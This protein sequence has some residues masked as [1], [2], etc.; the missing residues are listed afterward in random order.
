M[1]IKLLANGKFL[2]RSTI[3][4]LGKRTERKR[5]CSSKQEALYW[6]KEF[7]AEL[8]KLQVKIEEQD[9]KLWSS[10]L[11]SYLA[12]AY[13]N[14]SRASA[15]N[16]EVC[17][18]SKTHDWM[19]KPIDTIK[20]EDISSAVNNPSYRY[21]YKKELL[22]F[23]RAVFEFSLSARI[24]D[25]NPCRFVKIKFDKSELN[26]AKV[27]RAMTYKET[28]RLLEYVKDCSDDWYSIFA[29]TYFLGLR[30]SEAIELRV[31]DLDFDRKIVTVSRSWCKK[32]R[33]PVPPK[34][35]T[36]RKVPM[37][38]RVEMILAQLSKSK[39]S[40]D[41]VLPRVSAWIT[42]MGAKTLN[43]YQDAL[44]IKRSNYHSLRASFITHLLNKDVPIIKVQAMVGH[45]D[46]KTTQRYI[47][48]DASD[49]DGVTDVLN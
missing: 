48:L 26:Q 1:S 12:Y 47:R 16:R 4:I 31:S 40:N 41:Y 46:L 34:N 25:V 49:L 28:Q 20:T 35:G 21:S 43:N 37:A 9:P 45:S 39:C 30:L 36:S 18:K 13:D 24:T 23:I 8:S 5:V 22:K 14:F 29:V 42:G 7:K 17:L 6:D 10:C 33:G 32:K 27:L 44:G 2:T 38:P 19:N 3:T 15:Y 11:K